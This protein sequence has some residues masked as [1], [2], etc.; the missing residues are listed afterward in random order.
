M[1][2]GTK[3]TR[4]RFKFPTNRITVRIPAELDA[5]LGQHLALDLS[6]R[7]HKNRFIVDAIEQKLDRS[8]KTSRRKA[9]HADR[10]GNHE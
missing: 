4:N 1:D 5:R 9:K 10:G 3:K 8:I 7:L 6:G 2:D